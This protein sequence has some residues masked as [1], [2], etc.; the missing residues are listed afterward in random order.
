MFGQLGLKK[1]EIMNQFISQ[2]V[3]GMAK[4]QQVADPDKAS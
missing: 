4:I 1:A 2:K 3:R